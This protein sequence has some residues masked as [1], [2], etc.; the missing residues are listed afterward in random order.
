[1]LPGG[2]R[3]RK[4][5]PELLAAATVIIVLGGGF[6]VRDFVMRDTSQQDARALRSSA[7]EQL[8]ETEDPRRIARLLPAWVVQ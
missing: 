8:G 2:R 7:L 3:R 6:A 5:P 1:M 4:I